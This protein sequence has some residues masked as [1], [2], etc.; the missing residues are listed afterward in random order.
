MPISEANFLNNILTHIAHK[1]IINIQKIHDIAVA[2]DK[3][4]DMMDLIDELEKDGYITELN[5]NY[6]FLSPFL[7]AFWKRN[8]PIYNV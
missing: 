3:T 5:E 2:H 4:T 7:K 8:N 6:I 1:D